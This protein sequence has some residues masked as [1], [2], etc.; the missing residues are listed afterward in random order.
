ML[1]TVFLAVVALVAAASTVVVVARDGYRR[2][3][4]RRFITLP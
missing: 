2:I 4:T 1:T 3:P